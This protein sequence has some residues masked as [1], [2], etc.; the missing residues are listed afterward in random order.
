[1]RRISALL[2]VVLALGCGCGSRPITVSAEGFVP[3]GP[4]V[5]SFAYSR[6]APDGSTLLGTL[7]LAVAEVQ[8][9]GRAPRGTTLTLQTLVRFR[10]DAKVFSPEQAKLIDA[11]LSD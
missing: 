11:A 6:V 10:A 3:A 7:T 8:E 1:M 2:L 5:R 4:M 9:A